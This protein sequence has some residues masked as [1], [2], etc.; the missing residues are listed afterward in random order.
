MTVTEVLPVEDANASYASFEI[1]LD[2]LLK[3]YGYAERAR[4]QISGIFHSHPSPPSPSQ[5]DRRFMEINPVVWVIYSTTENRF[6]AWIYEKDVQQVSI[7]L[8][9]KESGS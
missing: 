5:T 7:V 3:A 4:L 2:S 6:A 8:S 9:K 1:P